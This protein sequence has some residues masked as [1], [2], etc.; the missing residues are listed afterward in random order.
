MAPDAGGAG[1]GEA[2]G[3]SSCTRPSMSITFSL[4]QSIVLGLDGDLGDEA[5]QVKSYGSH[6]FLH[7]LNCSYLTCTVAVEKCVLLSLKIFS[8]LE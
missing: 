4:D 3:K 8:I 7:H 1:A 2:G 6:L 5:L